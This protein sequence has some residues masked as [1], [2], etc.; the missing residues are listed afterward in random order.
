VI[1]RY[2]GILRIETALLPF[3][4]SSMLVHV[5]VWG[6]AAVPHA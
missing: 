1:S 6:F 3:C 2:S 4:S 5:K